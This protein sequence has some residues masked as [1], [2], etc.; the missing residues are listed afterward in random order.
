MASGSQAS[1]KS[2]MALKASQLAALVGIT[3]GRGRPSFQFKEELVEAA[4]LRG[5][6]R[7]EVETVELATTGISI[8]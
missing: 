6:T 7:K 5:T 2:L 1:K 4:Y 3:L 8:S